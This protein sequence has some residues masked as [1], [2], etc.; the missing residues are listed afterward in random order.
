MRFNGRRYTAKPYSPGKR[1]SFSILF[2]ISLLASGCQ[3]TSG[4]LAGLGD[5]TF[6]WFKTGEPVESESFVVS[7]AAD[8]PSNDNDVSMA[9]Q[10]ALAFAEKKRFIEARLLLAGVREFQPTD[11]DGYRALSC[12]MALLAL[13]EGDIKTFKRLARQLDT[14]L[15]TPVH[16]PPTYLEVVSLYRVFSN[17]SL[18]VNAP[19]KMQ[20][21]MERFFP[22]QSAEN[23][24]G[25]SK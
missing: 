11:S 12:S 18:P 19:E 15:G 13:R 5:G 17:G 1:V 20:R 10:N 4:S 23:L 8:G 9:V 24:E 25:G 22:A 2:I 7:K 21:L 16:V 6:N 3:G 14:S